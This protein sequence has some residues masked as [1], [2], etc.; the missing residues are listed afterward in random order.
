MPN[1]ITYTL[2]RE[3]EGSD[4]ESVD[5]K[6]ELEVTYCANAAE[7][8]V[9]IMSPYADDVCAYYDGKPFELTADEE[10]TITSYIDLYIIG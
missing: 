4:G 10:D 2:V 9:G 8:D 6:Y 1:N 5:T 7:P 3:T